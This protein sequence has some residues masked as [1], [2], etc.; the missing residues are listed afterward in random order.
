MDIE[1]FGGLNTLIDPTNLP[2]F[3]SPD[4]QD[5][6]FV[7]GLV[8]TRPGLFGALLTLT[9]LNVNYLKTYITNLLDVR[10]LALG[11][12][13]ALYKQ[14]VPATGLAQF[15]TIEDQNVYANSVT[16]FGREFMAFGNGQ[17]GT[18][19]P[20]AY[21]DPASF[22][23]RV[24]QDGPG[25]APQVTD[26]SAT[27]GIQA[28]PTGL[29]TVGP[30]TI[31]TISQSG[32]T[33]TFNTT[34]GGPIGTFSQVGDVLVIAGYG[35]AAAAYNGSQ[36][37]SAILG[38]QIFQFVSTS[39]GLP[40]VVGAGNA[41]FGLVTLNTSANFTLAATQ[42]VTIAGATNVAYDLQYQV[43]LGGTA[44]AGF[45]LYSP[46]IAGTAASGG[47]T[48]TLSGSVVAGKHMVSVI[49]VKRG[50]YL[51]RPAPPRF[52]VAGG[53]KRALASSIPIGPADVVQRILV[54]SAVNADS[55]FF[56]GAGSPLYSGNMVINDNTTT[57]A[58]FD[59]TDATL[60]DGV[61]VDDLFDLVTLGE[62]DSVTAYTDRLF[63]TG[64]LNK[65]QNFVNLSFAGGTVGS[66]FG[67]PPGWSG[68][69]TISGSVQPDTIMG[70][71]YR[72][73]GNGSAAIFGKITQSAY[74]D[75][76]GAPILLP[77]VGYSV[78]VRLLNGNP[79]ITG[80]G[81]F[82]IHLQSASA[83]IDTG[84]N[85][86]LS[87]VVTNTAQP[88]Q[89]SGVLT[90]GLASIP[91]DLMLAI[92]LDGTPIAGTQLNVSNIEVY[93]TN[94]P[95]NTTVVRVSRTPDADGLYSAE[96]YN[97]VDGFLDVAPA[98]GQASKCTFVI[99]DFLYIAKERSLYVTARDPNSEPA[100]WPVHEVSGK[101]GT[102]SP[103]GVGLGD[104]WAVIAGETGAWLFEG[105]QLT[106][107]N[108]L[109][110]EIQPTWDAINW[111]LGYLVDV[112]ID[113]KRK[114]IYFAVPMGATATQNN[115][116]L[117][118]DYTEGFGDPATNGGVGRK[119]SPWNIP[120]NSMNLIQQASV[121][122][123]MFGNNVGNG[124]IYQLDTTGT[125]FTDDGEKI[126]DYWQSGYFQSITRQNFGLA[127]TNT[128]GVGSL[129]LLLRKGDQ[130]WL[131]PLRPW[132]LKPTGFQD[133]E[134]NFPSNLE[135][136]RMA[137]RLATAGVG[138]HFSMQ[139]LT[140]WARESAWAATR[141]VNF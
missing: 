35:G 93:P 75:V 98:N 70:N 63:W 123:F 27:V 91:S 23:D 127:T 14:I 51:T 25:A 82:H 24:S 47:G 12:N 38:P 55:F 8:R 129:Q 83:S 118:L 66:L 33:V 44:T 103:R 31:G 105:G 54:F 125:I 21:N 56:S 124:K 4:C 121:Q 97:G 72:I 130:Q 85:I 57:S 65:V 10:A 62:A 79:S 108:N 107:A 132:T 140:L 138:D 116:V 89:Y 136:T 119:W 95:Y 99:R 17:F 49:F 9:G 28:S 110:K 42:L 81:V 76:F 69:S 60:L 71:V 120:C 139:G 80:P 134:R 26:E 13:G 59:F 64:E 6:E 117:T 20:R 101:V 19:L 100:Q 15:G 104:E 50:G 109:S 52:W 1:A 29:S 141:G 61:N 133:L 18:S 87:A 131:T 78:R 92:Y 48:L 126:N 68:D 74:Q 43:R 77:N 11:S 73:G 94:Q 111:N 88:A 30:V 96:S 112:K 37:I 122:Q 84:F 86:A 41:S 137:I 34:I 36:T 90:V 2:N 114:R 113:T 39:T 67:V 102:L 115:V 45:T 106:D 58:A 3:M 128:T 16:L 135:T 7:P 40:T 46:V 5:N 32:N 22:F 53:G